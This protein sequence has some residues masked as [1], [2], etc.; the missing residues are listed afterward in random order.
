M[1]KKHTQKLLRSALSVIAAISLLVGMVPSVLATTQ[2]ESASRQESENG[3]EDELIKLLDGL[4]VNY[5]DYLDSNVAFRLPDGIGEEE[6]ISIIIRY[7]LPSVMDAYDKTD[8]T[9]SLLDYS[10]TEEAQQVRERIRAR[11]QAIMTTLTEQGVAYKLGEQYDTLFSGFE[12]LIKGGDYTVT[13]MSMVDGEQVVLGNE[14]KA[15]KAQLVENEVNVYETGIFDA[16]D[17]PYDGTGMVVA[18]LDTGLDS[19]HPAFSMDRFTSN[20][21]G[22]TYDD[23][24]KLVN[25]TEAYKLNNGL[26]VDDVFINNKV[27]FGYDYADRD[28]DVY[29]THNNHGTH[30]S[31]VIVGKDDTITGVAP[32]AQLVS[33]KIFSDIED[34]A[35]SSWI[36]AALEDCVIL[37]VDVI[38]MSLGTACGFSHETE[39]EL[40][41]GVYQR[42]RDAGIHVVVAASNSYNSAYG[43]EA[44]GNLPLTSNPDSGTVGSPGTYPG[45]LS[46]GSVSG[47]ETPYLKYGDTIIYFDE[48]N[49]N[50]AKEKD[51]CDTL[52]GSAQ[53]KKFEY[54]TVPGVGRS[55]DYTGLDVKGKIAL[56]RRGSNT[57]EEKALIAEAQGAVGIIIYNN[58]SGDIKMNIGDATLAVCSISQN[59]GEMLAAAGKGILN[60]DKA[61]TSGPFMS[62]FSSWGPTPSLGI[63]PEIT[64]HGGNILSSITGG[65]YDH[66]SGTSMACP[67]MAGATVLMHQYVVER[68]PHLEGNTAAV[69]A[70]ANR[71]MMSTADILININGQPYAVRKQGSGLANLLDATTTDATIIT[72][73]QD[74]KEMDTSKL[75]LG[76]DPDKKGVYTMTFTVDNFG[77]SNLTYQV[78]A[79]VLTEGVS[80]TK[81]N[82]GETTVTEEAVPLE[83]AQVKVIKLEGGGTQRGNRI[84]V[85]AGEKAK[86]TVQVTLTDANKKYLNESFENGMYVE[87]FV[88]LNAILGTSIDLNVPYL[89]FYGDWTQAPMFDLEYYDT[90]ADELDTGIDAEDK[91]MADAFPSRAVGGISADF[92][93]YLGSYYFVQ[94]PSDMV[95]SAS[96]DYIAISNQEGSI[97]SLRFVWAGMLRAANT[98]D[99]TIKNAATGEIVYEIEEKDIRKSYGDG[100]TIRPSNIE[101]EFDMKEY[102]LP[103]NTKLTVELVGHMDYG[104]GGEKANR[105]RTMTFPMTVDFEAPTVSDVE[106]YYEHDK[107]NDKNKLFAKVGVYDNHFAMCGQLGYVVEGE[108]ENGNATP[109]LLSFEQYMTPIYSKENSTTYVTIEL[110]DY[111]YKIKEQAINKNTFVFT[112]YDYALNYA[113]YEIR[114]PDAITD[115]DLNLPEEGLILNPNE[116]KTMDPIVTPDTAWAELL[117]YASQRPD[118][119]RV[120]NNK[121]VAVRSGRT[122]I[123]VTNPDTGVKKTFPVTVRK[124]GDEGY[125]EETK[126]VADY[127]ILNGYTTRKAYYILENEKKDI[128]DTGQVRFFEG[129]NSLALYPSESVSL[130]YDLAPF[131]PNDIQVVFESGNENIVKISA[132]GQVT[133]V[134][135]GFASVTIKIM[136][137][138]KNTIYSESVSVEVKDP[139]DVT[140]GILNH[141]YGLGGLVEIPA[142][143]KL[144]EIGNFAFANFE[145]VDKTPE[146]LE[147]DDRETT[148]QWFIGDGTITKVVIPEGVEKINAY[149]F[150]NLTAL[151]EVVLPSTL[152][153]I[154]YGAFYQCSSLK[155]VTFSG[156]NKLQIINQHAFE[157]CDLEG[158]LDL[159]AACVISDYAFAGNKKLEKVVT[160]KDLLSISQYAFAACEKLSDITIVAPFVKYGAYAF[161]GCESLTKFYVNAAVLPEGMF[162]KCESLKEVTI[163]PDVNEIGEFA[164]RDTVVETF[165]IQAGNKAYK[166]GKAAYILSASGDKLMAVAP[167]TEGVFD[168]TS[169]GGATITEVG[170]GAFSHNQTITQ[171]NLPG[172][173]KVGNYAF[174]SSPLIEK[175]TL[176]ALTEIGE[177][178]FF[179]TAITELPQF[180]AQTKIGRY[181]FAFSDVTAVTVPDGM[182]VEEG[183]FSECDKL[184]TVVVGDNVTLGKY[185]FGTDKDT[186][187]TV[188]RKDVGDK[189]Y[190][191]YTFGTA[192]K[193]V[194]IGENVTV[195]ETAFTNAASLEKVTLGAGAKLEKMAFYNTASLKE[196]DLSKVT[197]IGDYALSG[198]VYYMCLDDQM[199]VAAVDDTGH[200]MYTYHAPL[201]T[202]A[203]L[204]SATSIGEYAFAYCRN[205]KT[206]TLNKEI[207]EIKPYT[208]AGCESLEKINLNRIE[209]VG[210]Y[211]FSEC[212][213]LKQANLLFAQEIGEYAFVYNKSLIRAIFSPKGVT[214]GEGAFSYCEKLSMTERMSRITDVGAY[215]FA[216]TALTEADLTGAAN[217]GDHAFLKEE[218]TPFK[219]TLSEALVTIGDNP[220]AMCVI[221]PFSREVQGDRKDENTTVTEYTFD[222]SATVTVNNGSLYCKV[223]EGWE[224]ITYLG[225]DPMKAQVMEDTV[226]VTAMAFTGSDVEM[227]TIPATVAAL[228]HKSFYDCD[229]LKMVSFNSYHAPV[230]EEAYDPTYYETYTHIP[231]AGEY[232]NYTDYNGQEVAI[233]GEGIIPFFMWNATGGMYSN[234]FYG[235]NFKDY[236]GYVKDKVAMI[237]PTNGLNYDSYIY[238]HYFDVVLD[239]GVAAE[240]AAAAAIKAIKKI[241][242]KGLTLEHRPLVEQARATYEKVG[243]TLQ[244]GLVY[245]YSDLTSAESRLTALEEEQAAAAQK[246][247]K[248]EEESTGCPWLLWTL[249]ILLLIGV[250]LILY[251]LKTGATTKEELLA[252]VKTS[253]AFVVAQCKALPQNLKKW[254]P[255]LFKYLWSK[256]VKLAKWFV[257]LT[258]V[259]K[260]TAVC[261]P[262][263]LPVARFFKKLWVK[264]FTKKR[265]RRKVVKARQHR[266]HPLVRRLVTAAL[267]VGAL[268]A[269][270]FGF[271][272]YL[273][274]TG[275]PTPYVVN[276]EA[277]YTVSVKYD[278]NG[279]RFA[280]DT[281]VVIDTFNPDHWMRDGKLSIQLPQP[282]RRNKDGQSWELVKDNHIFVGWYRERTQ[283]G[284]DEKGEAVYEYSGLW[285]FK[286]DRLELAADGNYH[287]AE[288]VQTLYAAW[289][290]WFQVE[291][292]DYDDPDTLIDTK[293]L[294]SLNSV[295]KEF[296]LPAF[297]ENAVKSSKGDFTAKVTK[298]Y[299]VEGVYWNPTDTQPITEAT[300]HHA[301]KVNYDN[302][303]ASNTVLKLYV[304]R[305]E[306]ET[307]H[308]YKVRDLKNNAKSNGTYI[309]HNDL[310]FEGAEWPAALTEE[311]FT[312]T[313]VGNGHTI[314]N[315]KATVDDFE[316][317]KVGLFCALGDSAKITNLTLENAT[318]TVKNV[319]NKAD[320]SIGLL[321]GN[322]S[323]KA[324]LTGLVI[325]DALLEIDS[326][327][328]ITKTSVVGLLCGNSTTLDVSG[329][330]CQVAGGDES[331]LMVLPGTGN[332]VTLLDLEVDDYEPELPEMEESDPENPEDD[333]DQEITDITGPNITIPGAGPEAG[334]S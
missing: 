284:V 121:L 243:T 204:S 59:D 74:G 189:R 309:L 64:A 268:A 116:V 14:Y 120:V 218:Y 201:I 222:I 134:A 169:V 11:Q 15:M 194:T 233:K 331:M 324:D 195:G 107:A 127:F 165:E 148:K 325:K 167:V 332:A 34:S 329:I 259:Q 81:T 152:N 191:H 43:S 298:G 248:E 177:Y 219:V 105:S 251:R 193:N 188:Q 174:G 184:T 149:A 192:L 316:Q 200:Y 135:E 126:K 10:A 67:N 294:S 220:F 73:D 9:M 183:V 257:A 236:V 61:Q 35:M 205:M 262:V 36:L 267:I 96:R 166:V 269:V 175:V 83:G 102:N 87:G 206:V 141:Y 224:L 230:L 29:S 101:I 328:K 306:G 103:N 49:D 223:P 232:G 118:I 209:K 282:T 323:E 21:L 77:K 100:G 51:F 319:S 153:S 264:L 41:S 207:T 291:F 123:S 276:Q 16:S 136:Q 255:A 144:K 99:I 235:A 173:T 18:V 52:L 190:F 22:L 125:L 302:G 181:A 151:E 240:D 94:D 161:N 138:G 244:K 30:V 42:L 24:A 146:E 92:V 111:I 308:I 6:E 245:N 246:D 108:D 250:G 272:P 112:T 133:A 31:G 179:E 253:P 215:A 197:E 213:S 279:G 76:H 186:A 237:R 274:L 80:E 155:K 293:D 75:E 132:I 280:E 140:G 17:V 90:N 217:I 273:N 3:T 147:R 50:A 5:Q 270:V 23:V 225:S 263:V 129:N 19:N 44:N 216:Y 28:P 202:E 275:E 170:K 26:S 254:I 277:G 85:R 326:R 158:E 310:D 8:K 58:V 172:V 261:K 221:D 68:F 182:V 320:V 290:P 300:I 203:D 70:M 160:G 227:V 271:I 150:A 299:T 91:L 72:Y 238:N 57:F 322:V 187:F 122:L 196:I 314:K 145:Y 115:F 20:K 212:N 7:D 176:G 110:T 199:T 113:T 171:V 2:T 119:V 54:V 106:Y 180:N 154:E 4:K 97:C 288:P 40:T 295:E 27:P 234:V 286:E 334:H 312:G 139:Y 1:N 63:K 46:I 128:G 303:T 292:Y 48:A 143:L 313:I 228:G 66:L 231:G 142:R 93:S 69:T 13:C 211:S 82:A 88:E 104:D 247:V 327:C 60:V 98:I 157:G 86:V 163:G 266:E 55:A 168:A 229:D 252:C 130:N 156:A 321:G 109:E 38:N 178:A 39:E 226:R 124:E 301:G 242:L 79:S 33:M 198:D 297:K 296:K 210:A 333:P 318:L 256:L 47:V 214:V 45:T 95:I 78:D 330:N 114:L 208:F 311:V 307:Y 84:T 62:D 278:A 37:G 289:V 32:N 164:F 260:V 265:R 56:V 281:F 258:F 65:G 241:P 12:L 283:V 25:K 137:D 131:Y 315:F 117:V 185:A 162:N 249:L 317:N 53:S 285:D 304:K 305:T 159:S 287:A 71:L 89:A 239:G